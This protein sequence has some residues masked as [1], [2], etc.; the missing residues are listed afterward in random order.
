MKITVR[1]LKR[2][3]G[4]DGQGFSCEVLFGAVP[5]C[6]ATN[7]G[8]GGATRFDYSR[9]NGTGRVYD[10]GKIGSEVL[11]YVASLPPAEPLF[12][13]GA[14]YRVDLDYVVASAID[15]HE[16]EKCMRLKCRTKTVMRYPDGEIRVAAV[17]W[18]PA[19][20]EALSKI[21]PAG[22]VFLNEQPQ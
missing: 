22:T 13:G 11:T 15:V 3:T 6:V 19:A 8:C 9:Y 16:T 2:W 14:P 10:L 17:R 1:K 7:D 21:V 18:S 5:F 4:R 12:R 20:K